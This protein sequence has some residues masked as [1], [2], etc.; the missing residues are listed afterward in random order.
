MISLIEW[1]ALARHNP[2]QHRIPYA[3]EGTV[4]FPFNNIPLT[5]MSLMTLASLNPTQLVEYLAANNI[6]ESWVPWQLACG[7][8]PTTFNPADDPLTW[9]R[10]VRAVRKKAANIFRRGPSPFAAFILAESFGGD[11]KGI[12]PRDA[13]TL[14]NTVEADRFEVW[15]VAFAEDPEDE[16][17]AVQYLREIVAAGHA[18]NFFCMAYLR[19]YFFSRW[20]ELVGTWMDAHRP[21]IV[22]PD[23]SGQYSRWIP[24]RW[25]SIAVRLVDRSRTE[26]SHHLSI[27]DVLLCA[28]PDAV[29][30]Y[31]G[32]SLS[33]QRLFPQ[34]LLSERIYMMQMIITVFLLRELAEGDASLAVLVFISQWAGCARH[35]ELTTA[36]DIANTLTQQHVVIAP[37]SDL[38]SLFTK[39]SKTPLGTFVM[40]TRDAL[41]SVEGYV[42]WQDAKQNLSRGDYMAFITVADT[43]LD[44]FPDPDLTAA[45]PDVD[46]WNGSR[47]GADDVQQPPSPQLARVYSSL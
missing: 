9:L 14:V 45:F 11:N 47:I 46:V 19:C 21:A 22:E 30:Y 7:S 23:L 20:I 17:P 26:H 12:H 6:P 1:L 27:G 43:R 15:D 3:A 40:P 37:E 42:E 32:H 10:T 5:G 31:Y 41:M 18:Y 8:D 24:E 34:F 29:Y 36:L 28:L 16:H 13:I 4:A 38:I 44:S 35:P 33:L 2:Q 39:S 25:Y